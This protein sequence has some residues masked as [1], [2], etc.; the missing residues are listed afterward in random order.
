MKKVVPAILTDDRKV[1]IDM[2]DTCAEFTG[3]AQIDIMDGK[4]VPSRSI[5]LEDLAGLK[6]PLPLEAHLMVDNPL[7][8]L[9]AF[10]NFGA[11]RIIFHFEV[12]K[13]HLEVINK[14]KAEGLSAGIAVNPPTTIGDFKFI[15]DKVDA[16]LFMSVNPGFYGAEFIPSVLEKIKEF[17][18][19]FPDKIAGIDGGVKLSNIR[20]IL[21]SGVDYVC[22][23]SAILKNKSP[24]SAYQSFCRLLNE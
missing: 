14:I 1:F 17:R 5:G 9:T 16:V 23:G 4:F 3:Y 22:V 2:L 7:D 21:A 20:D 6:P 15:V 11:E 10:K 24:R 19:L 8:W 12:K 18:R 13:K